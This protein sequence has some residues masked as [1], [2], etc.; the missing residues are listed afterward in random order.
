MTPSAGA[1][2]GASTGAG[3]GA[4]AGASSAIPH[5]RP[6]VATIDLDAIAHNVTALRRHVA[7][8]D[9]C[10]VVKA[11]GYGHGAL[12]VG[13]AALAAGANW[14]A[15]ALVEEG[16]AL[17]AGGIAA[18]ILVLSEAPLA[19]LSTVIALGLTPTVYSSEQVAALEGAAA[20]AR[21]GADGSARLPVHLKVDTGM[22]R[23]GCRPEEAL[24]LA[25]QIAASRH[26][27]L[28]G[29]STHFAIADAPDDPYT[30]GQLAAFDV[31]LGELERHRIDPGIIHAANSAGGIAH[32]RAHLKM[33]R[34]GIAAYGLD[35]DSA[36]DPA[37]YGVRLRPAMSLISEVTHAKDLDAGERVS[38]GLKY[39]L[40]AR[41]RIATVPIGYADGVPRRLSSVGGEVLIRGRR[42]PIAGRVTMDQ[43]LVDTGS[44]RVERGDEVVLI[45][46]QGEEAIL[47]WDWAVALDTIAYEITCGISARVPRHYVG[48]P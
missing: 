10:V 37:R 44:T 29:V 4:G 9:M 41:S 48:G 30:E 39:K 42:H 18:P 32:R 7:P 38:Y 34:F 1:G 31:V 13:R 11:D 23:V 8:A 25:Q 14:L 15:V 26:L 20:L 45:G 43:I 19:A 47:A 36:L 12:P 17:R 22:H 21:A 2:A 33:V 40:E 27:T 24:A 6:T 5:W 16:A 35:P 28:G 3:A 46:R